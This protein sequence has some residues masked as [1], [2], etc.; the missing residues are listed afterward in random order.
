MIRALGSSPGALM[1]GLAIGWLAGLSPVAWAA[2]TA[3]SGYIEV[4]GG[5]L[6]YEQAGSGDCL[7]LIHD[8]LVHREVW[9]GQLPV[10]ARSYRVVCYDRRGYGLS[11]E[12]VTPYS[13]VEDLH[14]VFTQLGIERAWL[15]GMS[16]GGGLCLDYA[17]AYPDQ[18]TG[19]V[20]VGAVVSGF[21]YT[22]HFY[23]R[24]GRLTPA[25][26]ADP[27]LWHAYWVSEDPYEMAPANTAARA[28][29]KALI[30]AHPQDAALEKHRLALGPAQPALPRLGEITVP[31]LVVV[32]EH[33]IPDVHAHAG[34]I[35]AG[36]PDARRVVVS[37]AAHLVPLEQ[38]GAFN[39][40]VL[41]FVKDTSF[42]AR[43]AAE[44][45][46]AATAEFERHATEHPGQ[47]PFSEARMNAEG[48]A[49]LQA[50][51]VDGAIALFQ[52]NVRAYPD[53]WNVY[54]SLAEAYMARNDFD[55]AI[56]YYERSL[57]LNPDNEGARRR[58][59]ELR[60]R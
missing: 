45:L 8:G 41:T 37:D 3:E 27:E 36:L 55:R 25:I 48:Y 40:L 30:D 21:D 57:E 23:T 59:A 1:P 38:P 58:L 60:G 14:Q 9:E 26:W 19:L 32:G 24:G 15:I 29:M 18:V 7:L 2:S 52:L 22:T 39:D 28:R 43:L 42:F 47:A 6:F 12:P 35:D 50:G 46:A 4:E 10:F 53:S 56:E 13:D 54:D 20:L 49:R 31:A 16:A 33:D 51:D 11:D 17:L 34:A 44:G 5:R